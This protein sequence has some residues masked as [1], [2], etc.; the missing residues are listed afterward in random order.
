LRDGDIAKFAE[1][2]VPRISVAVMV[3]DLLHR[4]ESFRWGGGEGGT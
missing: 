4:P 1:T 2:E 3:R